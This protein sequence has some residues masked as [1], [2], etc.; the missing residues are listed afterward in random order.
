MRNRTCGCS[1]VD[2]AC[3]TWQEA[4]KSAVWRAYIDEGVR[5]TN[6]VAA[7]NVCK[8]QKWR[9]VCDFSM[10]E[11]TLTPTMKVVRRKVDEVHA[12]VISEM[13]ADGE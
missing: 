5:K 3:K 9:I 8:I 1:S 7:S 13:Y 10:P 12:K 2:P 11:G 6:A 4:A